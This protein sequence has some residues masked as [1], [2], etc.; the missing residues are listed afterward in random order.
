M[1][2]AALHVVAAIILADNRVLACRR[3]PDKV[4]A[5]MWEFPGGKVDPGESPEDAIVREIQEELSLELKVL[6]PYDSSDTFVGETLIR[7][8]T[9]VCTPQGQFAESSTDHD[10]FRWL[11]VEQL[12]S[13]EWALP[14]L[15]SV[16]RLLNENFDLLAS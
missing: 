9:I 10:E 3:S 8:Q 11:S 2:D 12:M 14:D 13:V 15:P 16:R 4:S 1:D 7:L 5:G 6:K